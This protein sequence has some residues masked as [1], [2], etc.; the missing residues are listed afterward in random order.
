VRGAEK[1][2]GKKTKI[3]EG[4]ERKR[5]ENPEKFSRGAKVCKRVTGIK[6]KEIDGKVIS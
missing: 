3:S 2:Q 1:L 5:E 6:G 4:K